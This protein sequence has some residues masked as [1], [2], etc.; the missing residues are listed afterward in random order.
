MTETFQSKKRIFSLIGIRNIWS[1][2]IWFSAL[3]LSA[4]NIDF[5]LSDSVDVRCQLS[6][7]FYKDPMTVLAQRQTVYPQRNGD[8]PVLFQVRL[9]NNSG[10]YLYYAFINQLIDNENQTRYP[11]DGNRS[12][13][14]RRNLQK[15]RIDQIKIFI[16]EQVGG[17]QS[18]I[19]LTPDLD[20]ESSRIFIQLYGYPLYPDIKLP[21]SIE[22]LLTMPLAELISRTAHKINW[23]FLFPA[24]DLSSWNL[25]KQIPERVRPYLSQLSEIYDGAMDADGNF[26]YIATGRPLTEPGINCSGFIKWIADGI[27]RQRTGQENSLLDIEILKQRQITERGNQNSWNNSFELE[28]DPYFGLD[29][30]RAIGRELMSLERYRPVG[31]KESDADQIP[32]FSYLENVGYRV[33]DVHALMYLLALKQPGYFYLGSINGPFGEPQLHQYFHEVA[34]FPYFEKNGT[35]QLVILDT[36]VERFENFL[37]VRYPE[38]YIHLSAVAAPDFYTPI[39]ISQKER[40]RNAL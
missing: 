32:F 18:F 28:R 37:Q 1:W 29:W 16:T 34:L 19:R 13:L 30:A 4:Q 8:P 39:P 33:K 6:H 38:N 23:K 14:V 27:Y 3:S 36:G 25:V 7:L 11:I 26:V 12:Y 17:M 24:Q 2:L 15:N 9:N 20:F 40:Y 35:F 10:E 5:Q 31:N 21:F 22:R